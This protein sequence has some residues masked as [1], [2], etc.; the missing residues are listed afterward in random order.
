MRRIFNAIGLAIA[1]SAGGQ[2]AVA[3]TP[4]IPKPEYPKPIPKPDPRKPQPLPLPP[5]PKPAP[6]PPC[7]GPFCP[8]T[9]TR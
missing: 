5:V 8:P 9:P 3:A 7:Y 1:L 6:K 4:P 2:L